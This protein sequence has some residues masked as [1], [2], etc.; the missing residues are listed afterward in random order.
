MFRDIYSKKNDVNGF[1][2]YI[3]SLSMLATLKIKIDIFG[4]SSDLVKRDRLTD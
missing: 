1:F 4:Q 2:T 3:H